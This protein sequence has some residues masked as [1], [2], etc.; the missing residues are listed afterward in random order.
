MGV[1]QYGHSNTGLAA[2]DESADDL[3]CN[4]TLVKNVR[5]ERDRALSGPDGIEQGRKCLFSVEKDVN[6]VVAEDGRPC[7]GFQRSAKRRII[8]VHGRHCERSRCRCTT[9]KPGT[10]KQDTH[11]LE[12]RR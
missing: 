11:R 5:F 4:L 6:A 2:F 3:V 1:E 10:E 8:D 7:K 9:G 12:S